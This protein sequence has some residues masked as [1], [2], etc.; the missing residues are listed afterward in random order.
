MKI[1][2]TAC[3]EDNIIDPLGAGEYCLI[4]VFIRIINFDAL[5]SLVGDNNV[6]DACK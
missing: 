5:Q 6:S 3:N 2:N 4:N 1:I